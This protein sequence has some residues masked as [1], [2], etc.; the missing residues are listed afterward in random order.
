MSSEQTN[1]EWLARNRIMELR[2]MYGLATDLIGSGDASKVKEGEAI[3]EEIFTPAAR[4]SA[5]G[6]E[7]VNGPAAW[8]DVVRNALEPYSATQHLIGTQVVTSLELP[9]G[10]TPGHATMVSYLHAWHVEPDGALWTF[11]G[12][13]HDKLVHTGGSGWQ[14]DGMH[15]ERV[16]GERR[17]TSD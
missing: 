1:A 12:T 17:P 10:D 14:I 16:T 15:L 8:A 5:E 13:Y 4:L 6:V 2:R 11:L 7:T 3:Y 9:E